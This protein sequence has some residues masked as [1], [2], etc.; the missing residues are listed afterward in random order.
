MEISI[1][2]G[3]IFFNGDFILENGEEIK[4]SLSK[5]LKKIKTKEVS[6]NLID[7]EEIDSA[8]LQLILSFCKTM[9]KQGIH[10]FVAKLNDSV[11]ETLNIS[12]LGKYLNLT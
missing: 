1:K 2:R 5:M 10:F 4:D 7:I 6:L 8:G 11:R 3:E 12:G 9:K